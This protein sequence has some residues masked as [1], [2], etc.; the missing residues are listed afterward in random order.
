MRYSL[1][2]LCSVYAWLAALP[3]AADDAETPV[4]NS[5]ELNSVEP[6]ESVEQLVEMMIDGGFAQRER[7]ASRLYRMGL[8]AV[9]QIS[10]LAAQSD[11]PE[12]STRLRAI[13]TELTEGDFL[14][15][16]TRFLGGENIHFDGW[17]IFRV[18]FGDSEALREIFIELTEQ[19]PT[20]LKALDGTPRDLVLAMQRAAAAYQHRR[21]IQRDTPTRADTMALFL[22]LI[23][24]RVPLSAGHERLMNASL[25]LVYGQSL[26]L[27]TRLAPAMRKLMGGWMNRSTLDERP[28]T[29]HHAMMWDVPNARDLALRTLKETKDPLPVADAARALA[30]FGKA[31]DSLALRPTLSDRRKVH[32]TAY[33]EGKL[34]E[35]Q[36]ADLAVVTIAILNN[37]PLG[38]IGYPNA[39]RDLVVG[40]LYDGIGFPEDAPGKRDQAI[41]RAAKLLDDL[42]SPEGT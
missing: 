5:G 28:E 20:L 41:K 29:L 34:L 30:R 10:K 27:D 37:V 40:F 32:E 42:E 11:D 35:T 25:D 13:A 18:E 15:R 3:V 9:E 38:D 8:P 19:H 23:N 26:R 6:A 33:Q 12:I 14:E 17:E 31:R 7:A 21:L 24:P 1:L 36:M 16:K 22:P 39:Q 2:L 4:A